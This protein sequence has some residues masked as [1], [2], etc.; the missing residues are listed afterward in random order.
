MILA[1][2][3]I[4]GWLGAGTLRM[5][6]CPETTIAQAR[7]LRATSRS[8]VAASERA[9]VEVGEAIGTCKATYA[10]SYQAYQP[11]VPVSVT[12]LLLTL[13]AGG[14][15][16]FSET[17]HAHL[18][19]ELFEAGTTLLDER[20]IDEDGALKWQ[21]RLSN[22]RGISE[23]AACEIQA[24]TSMPGAKVEQKKVASTPYK[25]P[26]FKSITADQRIGQNLR[27][28]RGSLAVS[29]QQLAKALHCM[30]QA[31][32]DWEAGLSR[33]P[34]HMLLAISRYFN[35]TLGSFFQGMTGE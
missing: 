29:E 7:H 10:A 11:K 14:G 3:R 18:L 28:I 23:R 27:N 34:A 26:T 13:P 9:I 35:V 32:L 24:N 30:E 20:L 5:L 16:V 8:I 22:P 17:H 2:S 31:V 15:W 19:H 21:V 4:E 1:T 33:V 25:W 12:A 6:I